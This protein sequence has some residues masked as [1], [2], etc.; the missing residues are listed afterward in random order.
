MFHVNDETYIALVSSALSRDV[1]S[2][3]LITV[4]TL[5][6]FNKM[7]ITRDK[8]YFANVKCLTST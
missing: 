7:D 4:F 6:L 8:T 3:F 5:A 2:V 1:L